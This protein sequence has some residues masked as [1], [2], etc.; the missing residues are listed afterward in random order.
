MAGR[1]RHIDGLTVKRLRGKCILCGWKYAMRGEGCSFGYPFPF[2]EVCYGWV[3]RR[4]N[5]LLAK[6]ER[7]G[8]K[9]RGVLQ[10]HAEFLAAWEDRFRLRDVARE[11]R[12]LVRE[13]RRAE[14]KRVEAGDGRDGRE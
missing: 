5:E 6:E 12:A 3:L 13:A 10:T 4:R 9:R 11:R 14:L 1:K 7:S 8:K 2:C